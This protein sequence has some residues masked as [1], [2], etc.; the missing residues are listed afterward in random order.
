MNIYAAINVRFSAYNINKINIINLAIS[1]IAVLFSL[2]YILFMIKFIY[3]L[4]KIQ[5]DLSQ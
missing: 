1:F 2:G 3:F 5:N 4:T